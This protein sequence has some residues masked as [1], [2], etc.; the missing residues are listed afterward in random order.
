MLLPLPYSVICRHLLLPYACDI[1]VILYDFVFAILI[2]FDSSTIYSTILCCC[3]SQFCGIAIILYIFYHY[4]VQSCVVAIV[5]YIFG[6]IDIISHIFCD[7]AIIF[8]NLVLLPLSCTYSVILP[9]SRIIY[10]FK[11]L[12]FTFYPFRRRLTH[13]DAICKIYVVAI[14]WYNLVLLP[15]SCTIL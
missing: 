3:P 5:L 4:L 2:Y 7:I 13:V 14:I 10:N 6:G 1:S 15:L 12:T 11:E 8:Y 9:L